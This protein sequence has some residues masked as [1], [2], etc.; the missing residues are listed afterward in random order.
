MC[1]PAGEILGDID[2]LRVHRRAR[3]VSAIAGG[4]FGR[5]FGFFKFDLRGPTLLEGA[6]NRLKGGE[7]AIIPDRQRRRTKVSKETKGQTTRLTVR[8]LLKQ[9]AASTSL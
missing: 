1:S 9:A 3:P 8:E 5:A 6:G 4:A 7:E 2:G